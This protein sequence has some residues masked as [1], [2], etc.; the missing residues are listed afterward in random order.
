MVFSGYPQFNID[1]LTDINDDGSYNYLYS[2]GFDGSNPEPLNVAGPSQPSTATDVWGNWD[3]S[4][5]RSDFGLSNIAGPG[6]PYTGVEV[7]G[8]PREYP[9]FPG[10]DSAPI[11][12]CP[13]NEVVPDEGKSC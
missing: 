1:D 13:A 4:F 6:Q 8:G 3:S 11:S 2:F 7:W 5:G 10:P 9:D 12:L